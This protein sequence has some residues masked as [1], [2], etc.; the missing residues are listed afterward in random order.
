MKFTKMHGLGNDFIFIE[1]PDNMEM[2]YSSLAIKLCH[3]QLGIGADGII[4]VLPSDIADLRM[5]IINADGSEANMCG[6]AI[7][8][9][10]KYAFERGLVQS[11]IFRIE[12]FAGIIIPEVIEDKGKVVAVRVNMGVPD[13][14]RTAVPMLGDELAAIN[15]MLPLG[16]DEINITSILMGVPHTM[17]FVENVESVDL[18]NIGPMVEKHSLFPKGTNVNFVEVL[19]PDRIKLR[20]WERGA[21]AT[22]ACGTGSCASAVASVLNEHTGR[23]VTVELQHGE[24]EIEWTEDGPVFMTG[25][26]EESF[27]GEIAI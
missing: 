25:P 2:D 19:S 11:K 8:C 27:N 21:G 9:Y 22:L 4:A 13:I 18:K 23:K 10:A 16:E 6:N 7:R 1:N 15:V 20:T 26:A 14:R 17:I 24:L 3:R 5:R 12:T